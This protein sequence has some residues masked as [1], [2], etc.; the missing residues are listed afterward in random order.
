MFEKFRRSVTVFDTAID[1]NNLGD[2][3]IMKYANRVVC[4][5]FGNR[6]L[7]RLPTHRVPSDEELSSVGYRALPIM[8]G[9]NILC[10]DV[11]VHDQWIHPCQSKYF[12]GTLLFAVGLQDDR[13]LSQSSVDW[14][15]SILNKKMMHSVRDS[16]TREELENAG[17]CNVLNTGCVTMWN[18]T[19][20]LCSSV[21]AGKSK[22]AILTL[23]H[24]RSGEF[25]RE[26]L[27]VV[28]KSY[29]KVYFW[30]QGDKDVE[31][32]RSLDDIAKYEVL[33]RNLAA[34]EKLLSGGGLDYIGTRLHGGIHAL[35]W[36]IRTLIV[37]VDSRVSDI[38]RD[39][40]LPIIE[41]ND[42]SK[43]GAIIHSSWKTEIE[44][45]LQAICHWK[46]QFRE[47]GW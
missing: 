40:C 21:P 37:D 38:A 22:R 47:G 14:Y 7:I 29:E 16:R 41:P 8:C 18:L 1:T 45:P 12:K 3:I 42:I 4:E 34:F 2:E 32:L 39:T 44:L 30:P 11:S 19:P 25:N 10:A 28:S 17:F 43:L 15:Q 6:K 13:G 26:L 31:F 36:G 9:T 24:Y 27:D 33:P 20:E 35:N 46:D 23:T 5:I